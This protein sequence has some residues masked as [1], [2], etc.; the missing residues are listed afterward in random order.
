MAVAQRAM[1]ES[2]S[3]WKDEGSRRMRWIENVKTAKKERK[4]ERGRSK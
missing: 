1:E 4:K 3:F 2:R